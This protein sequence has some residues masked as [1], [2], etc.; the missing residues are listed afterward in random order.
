MLY[1]VML[2]L[3]I[4]SVVT[5][6]GPFFILFP[7]IRK[8]RTASID[9][10][11]IYLP[12]FRFAVQLSKH[13]GHILIPTGII[14]MLLSHLSWLTSWVLVTIFI[15]VSSLYFIARAFSPTLKK[16]AEPLQ[17]SNR[18]ELVNKLRNSL[19][20]YVTLMLIML[21]FMVTKPNVW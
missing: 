13:S 12:T 1:T 18:M 16:L 15:L 4:T 19:I 5:A 9:E 7:L 20:L 10:L 2:Y 17:N 14:L 6:I 3:H 11:K 21:W 8:L